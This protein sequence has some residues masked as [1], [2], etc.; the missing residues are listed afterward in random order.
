[1]KAPPHEVAAWLKHQGIK[2]FFWTWDQT[3]GMILSSHS[4]LQ[5]VAG[6]LSDDMSKGRGDYLKHEGMF[7]ELSQHSNVIHGAFIHKT[8]RGQAQGGTR[9]WGYDTFEGALR[10]GLRLSAGMTRKNALAGLWWGGGKGVITRDPAL[11]HRDTETRKKIFEEYGRFI[12]SLRGCYITAEDVGTNTADIHHIFSTTRFVT[13]IPESVGGSGNPSAPTALGVVCGMEAALEVL[14]GGDLRGRVVAVQG[15]GN[16]GEPLVRYVLERGARRVI[17]SDISSENVEAVKNRISDG[18]L[19][20]RV[21]TAL[22]LSILAEECDILA[23]CAVGAILNE[24]TIPKIRAKIVCGA[25]NNQLEVPSRDDEALFLRGISYVPD[26]LVNRMGIVNCANEQY[27]YVSADPYQAQHLSRD[28]E[29]SIY[30][31]SLRVLRKSKESG[32]AP[33]KMALAMADEL[34]EELHPIFGHRGKLIVD[35]LVTQ[36]W[37]TK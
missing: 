16:V 14:D 8:R 33:G 20:A 10:D 34:A 6:A 11:D 28:W 23:P 30:Q 36:G 9:F 31:G 1:M 13:C 32:I 22:D 2:R 5:A 3:R 4:E 18:R 27:G 26:F 7:F 37:A 12:T 15:L 35:S 25:A 19:E 24:R 21:T 29:H 17:A